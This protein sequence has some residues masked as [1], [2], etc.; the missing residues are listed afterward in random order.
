[1]LPDRVTLVEVGPRDGLQAVSAVLPPAT[2]IELVKQMIAAGARRI[3]AASFVHPGLVPQMAGAEAVLEGLAG[4]G[5]EVSLIGLVL[6]GRGLERALSTAVD[7]VNL[8]V[9]ASEGY[10]RANQGASVAETMRTIEAMI[11]VAVDAGRRVTVTISV[12]FGDL[13]D[14]EVAP[15]AVVDLA[16]RAVAAGAEEIALGDTIGVA[17][18]THVAALVG[19]LAGAIPGIPIRCHF[20]DTR[21]AGLAN[22]AAALDSG[23]TVFDTSVGGLGGSPFAP[24]AGGNVATEDAIAFLGRMGIDTGYDLD[25]VVAAGRWLGGHVGDLPAALQH[26]E[27]WPPA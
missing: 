27:P 11:P 6:N 16:R 21:R 4:A 20:H 22:V 13:Y 9:A 12:A 2:R 17:V 1:M 23:V 25:A 24:A 5:S 15:A 14:G 10:S 18:P 7:E 8:V 19:A 3:E 26:A